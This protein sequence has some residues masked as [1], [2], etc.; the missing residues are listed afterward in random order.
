MKRLAYRLALSSLAIAIVSM[1]ILSSPRSEAQTQGRTPKSQPP[2][3]GLSAGEGQERL[4]PDKDWSKD[5]TEPRQF[6]QIRKGIAPANNG[7]MLDHAAQWYAYRLTHTEYQEPRATSRGMHDL[8]KEALDQIVDLRDPK[9]PATAAQRTYMEEFGKRFTARLREV[10]KN[11]KIIARLN[12]AILLARLAAAGQES[13]VDV[14]VEIIQD[15]K[16]NDGVKLYALRGLRELFVSGRGES[17]FT[18]KEREARVINGLLGY[19]MQKPALSRSA[20]PE[21]VAAV[22]YVRAEAITALGQTLYPA[23]ANVVKKVIHIERPTAWVLLRLLRKDGFQ[24][25]PSLAEQVAAAVGVCR[26]RTKELDQYNPD[27]VAYHVGRFL[28]DFA[29]LYNNRGQEEKKQPWKIYA[30]HLSNALQNMKTDLATP[31]ASEH[32][33]YVAKLAEQGDRLLSPIQKSSTTN[34]QPNDLSAWLDQNPPKSQSVYKGMPE[35][36]IKEG[37]RTAGE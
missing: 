32:A 4:L 2:A 7:E 25:E 34:P 28:V 29:G 22:D 14:L 13:A 15:P 27:Y 26:L 24:P 10:A 18:N 21:E 16:E 19:V 23:N 31:P 35:A 37:E 9:R 12:A 5:A 1:G 17:P 30:H 6:E 20:T 33:A 8:V 36:T 3:T 11:P